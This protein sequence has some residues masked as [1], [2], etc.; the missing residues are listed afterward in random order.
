MSDVSS[1][2]MAT[3]TGA[4][5]DC[6]ADLRAVPNVALNEWD[7][8]DATGSMITALPQPDW[9][10]LRTTDIATY[11]RLSAAAHLG[12]L[13]SFHVHRPARSEPYAGDVPT[14]CAMPM[15]LSPSGWVC[16]ESSH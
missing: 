6:G 5:C 9:D 4:V 15:R 3:A 1:A 14:C 11:S 8:V 16:R 13:P 10:D 2:T 12:F 7:W